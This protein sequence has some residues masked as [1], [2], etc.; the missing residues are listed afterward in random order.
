[1][2]RTLFTAAAALAAAAATPALAGSITVNY[3]DLNLA[4]TE[5]QAALAARIDR[6]AR[7]V[8]ELDT[9]TVGTRI[10]SAEKQRCYVEAKAAATQRVAMSAADEALG[11]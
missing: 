5:G 10:V 2:P 7:K 6:A 9:A 8:C 4:S 3:S 11:G 1:M